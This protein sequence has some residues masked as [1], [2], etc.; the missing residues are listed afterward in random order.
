[1]SHAAQPVSFQ[2][3]VTTCLTKKYANFS[4]RASRSEF[5]FF[6]LAESIAYAIAGAIDGLIGMSILSILV[7]LAL[8]VPSLAVG[9]RRLHDIGK[10]GWLQLLLIIPLLG[11]LALIF[12]W[13]KPGEDSANKYD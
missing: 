3:A 8:L 7:G 12:F 10:S 11:L 6:T 2:E 13:C 1:M 9:A 5:W 4:G